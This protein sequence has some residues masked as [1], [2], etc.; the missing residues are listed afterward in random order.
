[1]SDQSPQDQAPKNVEHEAQF[2]RSTSGWRNPYVVFV[3]LNAVLF[4]FLLLMAY[5]AWT[6]DWIPHR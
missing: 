6:N 5:L 2:T 1:M 3:V 4:G